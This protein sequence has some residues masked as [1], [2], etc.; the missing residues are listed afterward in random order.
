MSV[1]CNFVQKQKNTDMKHPQ[2]AL[3]AIIFSILSASTAMASVVKGILIDESLNEGEPFATVRIF[4]GNP[5][6]EALYSILTSVDGKP[7]LLF[8][9]NPSQIFKSMPASAVQSIEVVTNPGAR[10][11]AEGTGGVLNLVMDK[12]AGN[13]LD[14]N[15]YN[16][17]VSATAMSLS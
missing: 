12:Q 11:D 14:G 16:A 9:G 15:A 8:S 6:G 7:S 10:F 13:A 4:R 3:L 17:S 5:G 1:L 2:I